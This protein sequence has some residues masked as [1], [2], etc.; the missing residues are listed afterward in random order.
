VNFRSLSGIAERNFA[1]AL[2]PYGFVD[3]NKNC[4]FVRPL[5][6]LLHVI[7]FDKSRHAPHFRVHIYP[8]VPE[9]LTAEDRTGMTTPLRMLSATWSKIESVGSYSIGPLKWWPMADEPSAEASLELL[10]APVIRGALPWFERFSNRTDVS[11]SLLPDAP[12]WVKAALHNPVP[13][14]MPP[15]LAKLPLREGSC[16]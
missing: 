6:Q 2:A 4:L 12:T 11:A 16:G 7:N 13:V 3:V 10:I 14:P 8:W 5:P 15:I 1:P 9:Y